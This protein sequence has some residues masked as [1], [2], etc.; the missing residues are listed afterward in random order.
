MKKKTY[1]NIDIVKVKANHWT[2]YFHAGS[3]HHVTR[4]V[5]KEWPWGKTQQG[6]AHWGEVDTLVVIRM[7]QMSNDHP[8]GFLLQKTNPAVAPA[9]RRAIVIIIMS[10]LILT[11]SLASSLLADPRY[12]LRF[13]HTQKTP[14]DTKRLSNAVL[15]LC[16]RLQRWTN[17]NTT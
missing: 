2:D 3:W 8:D 1:N 6:Q 4:S 12:S 9:Q 17:I 11:I 5:D 13:G 15:M 7:R 10:L 16:H 14:A